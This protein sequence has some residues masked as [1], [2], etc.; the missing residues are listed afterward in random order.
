MKKGL[1]IGILAI[2]ILLAIFFFFNSSNQQTNNNDD[3]NQPSTSKNLIPAESLNPS[4]DLSQLSAKLT[5][6]NDEIQTKNGQKYILD[7]DKVRGGG[8]PKGGIGVDRGIPALDESNI[9]YTTVQEADT[10]IQDNEL[11]LAIIHKGKKRVYPLQIMVWHEI[12][13]VVIAGDPIAITY[14]PL[15]GSGIAYYRVIN[16]QPVKI[17]T[18]GKLYNSNLIMYD[19]LTETYWQQIDGKAIIG[20]LTGLE[21][22]ELN[23]DT[24]VWRDWKTNHPDSEVLSQQTGMNRNYGRDP[25]GDYY[26]DSFL[27][28][29]VDNEDNR[30]HPKTPILGVE[31]NGQFK[32]YKEDDLKELV[33]I[34]DEIDGTKIKL[35]IDEA[36]TITITNLDTNEIIVKERDFW[37]AWYAFHPDTDLYE[38]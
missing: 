24:V 13:N 36:G 17:G 32:A 26:E 31:I 8:P 19:D 30:I 4:T 5:T 12:A 6:P 28:F 35:E 14:C 34:N 33:I 7:P 20:E 37:F 16:N 3:N 23:I 29:P 38:R 2:I 1:L 21:L 9:Q 15:C 27:I 22:Q 25:Y 18:S 10:W 11:V